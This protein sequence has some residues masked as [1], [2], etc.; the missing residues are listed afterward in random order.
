MTTYMENEQIKYEL[1]PTGLHRRNLA[2]R[3]IQKFKNHVIA[4]L[5]R[6]HPDFPLNL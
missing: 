2:E 4:G 1:T 5:C 6:N 3:A